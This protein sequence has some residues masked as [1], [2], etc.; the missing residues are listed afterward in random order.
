MTCLTWNI[1]IA[2]HWQ[3]KCALKVGYPVN[4][5]QS[6][7]KETHIYTIGI[8]NYNGLYVY[9]YILYLYLYIY[10]YLWLCPK[11]LVPPV[12]SQ[13]DMT[14]FRFGVDACGQG[15][16]AQASARRWICWPSNQAANSSW[17]WACWAYAKTTV[18]PNIAMQDFCLD[19]FF[20]VGRYDIK[21]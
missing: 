17:C 1:F 15:P 13:L 14:Y 16:P 19:S 10:I 7:W 20:F 3:S 5:Q 12:I 4:N 9:I 2:V 18:D 11:M 21:S 8:Y 6:H